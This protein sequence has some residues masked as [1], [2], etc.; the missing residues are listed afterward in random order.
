MTKGRG[1]VGAG[2]GLHRVQPL[3]Q[4]IFTWE[5]G[6]RVEEVCFESG[7]ECFSRQSLLAPLRAPVRITSLFFP[8]K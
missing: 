2:P 8:A 6:G 5:A 3:F 7:G 1:A 4:I